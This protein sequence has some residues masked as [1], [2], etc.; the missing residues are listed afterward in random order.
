MKDDDIFLDALHAIQP[1]TGTRN[2]QLSIAIIKRD[3]REHGDKDG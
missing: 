1:R 2:C 3:V